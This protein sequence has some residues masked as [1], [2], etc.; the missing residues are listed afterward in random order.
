M[1]IG[2]DHFFTGTG[3]RDLGPEEAPQQVGQVIQQYV[4][5]LG[6]EDKYHHT[7]TVA[8]IKIADHFRRK[9]DQGLFS[10]FLALYPQ[11]VQNFPSLLSKHYRPADLHSEK[12]QKACVTLHLLPF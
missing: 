10:H 11:L 12:A 5:V 6:A 4:Q 2:G 3:K 1:Y 9:A 7:L 8:A